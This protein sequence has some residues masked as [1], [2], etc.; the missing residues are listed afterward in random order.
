MSPALMAPVWLNTR[1]KEK[2][3]NNPNSEASLGLEG[4]GMEGAI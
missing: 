2:L 4:R 3:P 1:F